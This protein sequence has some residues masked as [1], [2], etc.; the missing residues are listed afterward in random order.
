MSD[1]IET[2]SF[3]TYVWDESKKVYPLGELWNKRYVADIR[4]T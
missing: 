4:P 3:H 1:E 2:C